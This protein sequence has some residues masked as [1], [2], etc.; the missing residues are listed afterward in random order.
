MIK[1]SENHEI[2][3][4]TY[5]HKCFRFQMWRLVTS[6]P[7]ENLILFLIIM[8]T[9]SLMMKFHQVSLE[10]FVDNLKLAQHHHHKVIKALN[11]C[12]MCNINIG[13]FQAPL[14]FVDILAYCN[15]LFTTLFTIEC[16]FKVFALGPKVSIIQTF[17]KY[18]DAQA[19]CP[20]L[21]Q[22]YFKDSWNTFDFV[23]VVGSIVDVTKLLQIGFLKLFRAARLIKLLR[24]F[25]TIFNSNDNCGWIYF[26]RRSVSVRILLYTFIQSF[27]VTILPSEIH[28]SVRLL[29]LFFCKT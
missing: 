22:N 27:K 13:V 25:D 26:Y 29:G 1:Q 6:A 7:F 19:R 5:N 17:L 14:Y 9:V 21:F 2:Y 4:W 10:V 12:N 18:P 24:K 15:L 3:I 16:C 23:T 11:M 8:N 28:M 20:L